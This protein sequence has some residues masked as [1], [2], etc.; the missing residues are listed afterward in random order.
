MTTINYF[1]LQAKNLYKD[2]K[3]QKSY[4]DPN[5]DRSLYKYVPTF[6]DVDALVL[7]FDINEDNFT[8][9]NAQ[10]YIAKLA[11]FTKWTEMLKA[12]PSALALSKLLFDNM[13]KVSVIEWDIYISIQENENGFIFEDELKLDIF[14]AVFAEADGH[15]SDGYDYRLNKGGQLSNE[16]QIV[17][18]NKTKTIKQTKTT[19][20]ISV[21]PLAEDDLKEFIEVAN[22]K[23]EELMQMMEPNFPGLVRKL[24]NPEKYIDEVFEQSGLPIDRDYA[25]S[26]VESFLVH[27][28]ITLSVEADEQAMKL[29]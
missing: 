12:S 14:K 18:P 28:F 17:N 20:Q 25:L 3:T 24:W 9:M 19:M 23:F 4:F 5:Y 11:G 10:H 13:H 26:L 6:F 15:Q 7:D 2:F 16:N 27:H 21:L 22:W 29:N 1:K 8:L